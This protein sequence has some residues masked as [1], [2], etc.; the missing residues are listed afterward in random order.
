MFIAWMQV[1]SPLF[2][3]LYVCPCFTGWSIAA[4]EYMGISLVIICSLCYPFPISFF[5]CLLVD[6]FV[7]Y[8][9]EYK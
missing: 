8:E 9:K 2:G 3:V 4:K 7:F 1:C 6:H 5:F